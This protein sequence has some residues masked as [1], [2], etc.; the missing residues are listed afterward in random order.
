MGDFLLGAICAP[1]GCDT[2]PDVHPDSVSF[3]PSYV[4]PETENPRNTFSESSCQQD[5]QLMQ[6]HGK[7]LA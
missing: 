6:Y 1:Q 4:G 5:L 2:A 7:G 3:L